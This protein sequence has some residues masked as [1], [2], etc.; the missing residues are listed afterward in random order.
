M[1][2][3]GLLSSVLL[4]TMVLPLLGGIPQ[5]ISPSPVR[6]SASFDNW[7]MFGHD[8]AHTGYT[9]SAAPATNRTLWKLYIGSMVLSSSVSVVDGRVYTDVDVPDERWFEDIREI[10]CLDALTGDTIWSY[11]HKTEYVGISS[12]TVADGRVYFGADGIYCL[13]AS[14]G[15]LLWRYSMKDVVS[16]PAV[17]NNRLYVGAGLGDGCIYCLDATTGIQI[18]NVSTGLGGSGVY[19]SPAVVD[20]KVYVGTLRGDILCL[21]ALTGTIT[22][23]IT[24]ESAIESSPTVVAGKVYIGSY[25]YFYCLNATTGAIIW[26]YTTESSWWQPSPA[27]AFG[28]TYIGAGDGNFHC[29]N[30]TTGV[31]IWNYTTGDSIHDAAAVADGK[32]YIGSNDNNLYCFNAITGENIWSYTTG[33]SIYSS[34]TAIAGGVVY[35]RSL[36]GYLYAIS[37]EGAG[38]W[39]TFQYDATRVG[40]TS[41]T[42]PNRNF[43]LWPYTA[44]NQVSSS[45]AVVAGRLYFSTYDLSYE[46]NATIFCLNASTGAHLWNYTEGHTMWSPTV[47]GDRVYV[48]GG[49]EWY[50]TLFCFDAFTGTLLWRYDSDWF[51]SEAAPA[52]AYGRVYFGDRDDWFYCLDAATGTLLWQYRAGGS[53]RFSSPAV[54]EGR[55]YVGCWDNQ[56]YCLDA[57]SGTLHWTFET[58]GIIQSSPAVADSRVYVGSVDAKV[59]CVDAVTGTQIWNYTMDDMTWSSP[60]EAQGRV[61]VGSRDANVYCLNATTGIHIWSYETDGAVYSSPAVA[62]DRVYVGSYDTRVYCLDAATGAVLWTYQT[63]DYVFSSPA[64]ADGRVYIGSLDATMYAFGSR[65]YTF[66]VVASGTTHYVSVVTNSIVS[67][68]S[69]DISSNTMGFTATGTPNAQAFA[70][71]T[72]PAILLGGPYFLL[73]DGSLGMPIKGSNATHASL[74]TEYVNNLHEFKVIGNLPEPYTILAAILLIPLCIAWRRTR[75]AQTPS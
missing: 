17:V 23:N 46:D 54:V 73:Q 2:S 40:Y 15:T 63:G 34:F 4:V 7:P 52:V 22:W 61:Y 12:L 3:K 70:N 67:D 20:G 62:G 36:D 10:R 9:T 55:V 13:E 21:N 59:Y 35:F 11:Q 71:V 69:S 27:V 38:D 43:T 1:K 72:F 42:A 25:P 74:Y 37:D 53:F 64:V 16:S 44:R 24:T 32:V 39:P 31:R 41:T 48:G 5:V 75:S 30:S 56:L 18:W 6:A 8:P 49:F 19:S 47:A 50:S 28:R 29:L 57:S 14:T 45:P 66:P 33:D 65:T 51:G 68:F 26:N 58:G 60:A